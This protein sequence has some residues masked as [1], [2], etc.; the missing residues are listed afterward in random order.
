MKCKTRGGLRS[1]AAAMAEAL[2]NGVVLDPVLTYI[3]SGI[4]TS[5]V[6]AVK[7]VCREFYSQAELLRAKDLLWKVADANIVGQIVT[8]KNSSKSD[9]GD[10]IADD[11]VT[12]VKKLGSAG[13]LPIFAVGP[14]GLARVPKASPH[15]TMSIN[16]CQR[17]NELEENMQKVLNVLSA[18]KSSGCAAPPALPMPGPSAS[19]KPTMAGVASQLGDG[20]FTG[21]KRREEKT[22]AEQKKKKRKPRTQ[23]KAEDSE[24]LIG[25]SSTFKLVTTNVNPETK[26]E[27]ITDYIKSK[28][29]GV[30]VHN[31][32]DASS[33]GWETK[34]YIITF[35]RKDYET[36]HS[37]EFWP[38]R[39]YF[40]VWSPARPSN[41]A[42][43]GSGQNYG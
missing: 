37:A 15:E 4:N 34:R 19:T 20:D 5:T 41:R 39:V 26:K 30:K 22:D 6:Q 27:G 7:A 32:E 40:R 8:R 16:V 11:L 36:V 3:A 2:T 35:D 25:G 10:K 13:V 9:M 43:Q 14:M 33:E 42:G 28:S 29:P 38:P 18:T 24:I 1:F 31:V 21:V 12:A 23:G 17:L